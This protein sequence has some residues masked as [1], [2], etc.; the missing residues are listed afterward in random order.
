MRRTHSRTLLLAALGAALLLASCSSS[1][2]SG[3]AT[4]TAGAGATTSA[5]SASSTSAAPSTTAPSGPVATIEPITAGGTPF[6]GEGNPLPL[7]AGWTQ[8]EFTASGTATSYKPKGTLGSNGRWTITPDKSAPYRTRILVRR[9]T[10]PAKFSGTVVV[11]WLNVSGGVDANPDWTT[12]HEELIRQGDAWV[13][14]SAQ[15]NGVEGGPVLVSVPGADTTG[16]TGKGLKKIDPARYG[17]LSHPGDGWSFDIF[18][19]AARAARAGTPLLGDLVPRHVIAAGESQSAFALVSYIDGVQP[20]THAF[21]GFFVHSRGAS[22]LPF[23]AGTGDAAIAGSIGKTPAIFRTD[24]DVP[25]IDMQTESDVTSVLNSI[26]AR[27]PDNADFR[28]WEVVGTAHADKHLLGPAGDAIDCGVPVNDG[29]A[30]VV[31]KAAFHALQAWVTDGT[32][33][34]HAA[35]FVTTAGASPQVVRDVDGIAKGGVRT[36]PVDVPTATLSGAPGPKSSII[37]LLL[38]STRSIPAA[39]LHALYPSRA[40]FQRQYDAA[41]DK[42]IAAGFVL[43]AD[44]AAIEAYA[45]PERLAA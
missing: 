39:R 33:P 44:R 19:Q 2:S 3:S 13:G 16:V 43:A 1:K 24:T 7:P 20:L 21:D 31:G 29:P 22:G 34:P 27:Q 5:A 8:Q 30:H 15:H 9:P 37:C 28:L 25:I 10:D 11:E 40:D 35:R 23:D 38:G 26:A 14:V 32:P 4:T 41:V 17:T 42:A 12:L 18:T 36:P 6:I 45:H